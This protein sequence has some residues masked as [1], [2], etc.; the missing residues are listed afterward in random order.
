MFILLSTTATNSYGGLA[1][2]VLISLAATY[3]L[4]AVATV[5][6]TE[7]ATLSVRRHRRGDL[8]A[9]GTRERP[10]AA[11][12]HGIR[13]TFRSSQMLASWVSTNGVSCDHSNATRD[14]DCEKTQEAGS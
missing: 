3:P 13:R 4:G 6:L 8:R 7:C 11:T 14:T 1:A 10:R 5:T 2:S 9:R 12:H